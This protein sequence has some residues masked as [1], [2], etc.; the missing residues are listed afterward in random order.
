[1]ALN[2]VS[3]HD[4]QLAQRQQLSAELSASRPF[5]AGL[6]VEH[7]LVVLFVG[8]AVFV[9][10]FALSETP[11]SGLEAA[12]VW[13]AWLAASAQS[14]P[15]TT[16]PATP[17]FYALS[18]TIFWL[19]GGG[20]GIARSIPLLASL[21]M[22]VA[23][24]GFRPWLGRA[25]TLLLILLLA[26][27]PWLT[28][29]SRL[30]DGAALSLC[31][32]W[33]ALLG[34]LSLLH[35]TPNQPDLPLWRRIT[36]ISLG[37]LFVSGP[38]SWSFLVVLALLI[39]AYDPQA[40]HLR[41]LGLGQRADLVMLL[42]AALLGATAWLAQPAG[43]GL[44]STSL[45]VWL[46]TWWG[47]DG[48]VYPLSW[49]GLRLWADQLPLLILGGLGL[50]RL[51]MTPAESP[52]IAHTTTLRVGPWRFFLTTWL[53]WG[54]LLNLLPGRD[55]LNLPM[56][57]LPLLFAAAD[58][59]AAF[60]QRASHGVIWREGW[61]LIALM[62]V[63]LVSAIFWGAALFSQIQFEWNIVRGLLLFL[64]LLGL[65]V[66]LYALWAGWQITRLLIGAYG[67]LLLLLVTLSS[68]WH[69]NHRVSLSEPD[70][71]FA[72]FTVTDVR[73]LVT[74]VHLLSAQRTGDANQ[75]PVLVQRS[76]P[77]DPV[78]GWYLRNLR[79][80]RWVLAPEV[81]SAVT[82]SA[83]L[84]ITPGLGA[85]DQQLVDYM[86][87]RYLVHGHW[88]P[89]ALL[90]TGQMAAPGGLGLTGQLEYGWSAWLRNLLRWI[91]Y[92]EVP[93]TPPTEAVIL[94]VKPAE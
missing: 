38:L 94:W 75:M 1:M 65:T 6:T 78:L 7:L 47:G 80:L 14:A 35:A 5:W 50:L 93:M 88:L 90:G 29:F 23:S 36:L 87:S 66:V 18:T 54:I 32:G 41:T 76:G 62:T 72:E 40:A 22:I 19:V 91:T 37:L 67:I 24:F 79:N 9:R 92:R 20:D 85:D 39:A 8:V 15:E 43:L 57:S 16:L 53:L 70:G 10:A 69:L 13:P 59:A 77:P 28:F 48:S 82:A 42:V 60:L 34:L 45:T 17:L 52:L 68:N 71:I 63:L 21:V 84:V 12:N 2:L 89:G 46:S 74:N 44:I 25:T 56:I 58:L 30:A 83:P 51:W 86:G 49:L 3:P 81:Q 26:L 4:E 61:L 73:N 64:L 55:P 33:L 27:D 31:F 11:L